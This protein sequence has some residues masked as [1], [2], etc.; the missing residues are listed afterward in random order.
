M[1]DNENS[2][3]SNKFAQYKQVKKTVTVISWITK[4]EEGHKVGGPGLTFILESLGWPEGL[5]TSTGISKWW[6]Q[7][8][9]I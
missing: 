7:R 1:K 6:E 3:T 8:E 5:Y 2:I 9:M 4:D